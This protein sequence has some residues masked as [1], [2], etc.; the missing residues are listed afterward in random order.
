MKKIVFMFVLVTISML[1]NNVFAQ[2]AA[3]DGS[4]S[5]DVVV[6]V[7][8][9]VE[10]QV[11]GA[12][13]DKIIEVPFVVQ[14]IHDV[15]LA[16]AHVTN[17]THV[18]Q[19]SNFLVRSGLGITSYAR[20]LMVGVVGEIGYSDS[21]WRLQGQFNAGKC[22]ND[23]IAIGGSMALMYLLGSSHVRVGVGADL[24]YCTDTSAHPNEVNRQRF[25]G[26]SA[27]IGYEFAHHLLLEGYLGSAVATTPVV[28]GLDNRVTIDG[29]VGFS[30]L[31]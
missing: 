30:V 14:R 22:Q 17:V 2:T 18:Q 7:P 5:H 25:V 24:L 26:G 23:T 10:V 1:A 6:K 31:F 28:G 19:G 9:D 20:S 21:S 15:D 12:G 27:R 11:L 4:G 16:P 8:N 29:G 13:E 3:P